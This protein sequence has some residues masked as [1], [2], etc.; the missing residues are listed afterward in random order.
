MVSSVR[1]IL[2]SRQEAPPCQRPQPLLDQRRQV[3]RSERQ[4]HDHRLSRQERP[5][6][7]ARGRGQELG[8]LRQEREAVETVR[9]GL[10][11]AGEVVLEEGAQLLVQHEP[12]AG[13]PREHAADDV[14]GGAARR[15]QDDHEAARAEGGAERGLERGL[16][17][18]DDQARGDRHALAE[19]R[20]RH[21]PAAGVVAPRAAPRSR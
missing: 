8:T 10:P 7:L 11:A 5:A 19:E 4:H 3:R 20:A 15:R 21:P 6:G 2:T 18:V 13:E 1:R 14:A 12:G 16:V 17:L 9:H